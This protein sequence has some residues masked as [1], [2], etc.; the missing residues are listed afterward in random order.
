MSLPA[1]GKICVVIRE[2]NADDFQKAILHNR[3]N[4]DLME[5]R[6]DYLNSSQL[7]IKQLRYWV[8]IS[9]VPVIATL[10]RKPFGGLFS[11]SPNEQM[12]IVNKIQGAGFDFVDIELETLEVIDSEQLEK[13][14]AGSMKLIASYHNFKE[15]PS[16]LKSVFDRIVVFRPEVVK[17]AT[18]ALSFS[19]NF[20]LI[21]LISQAT[22]RGLMIIPV[23]MGELGVYSRVIAPSRGA[24]L[25]YASSQAGQETAP[26]Q[27]TALGLKDVYQLNLIDQSTLIYGVI[28]CPIKHSMSPYIH[29]YAFQKVGLK[30]C[31]LPLYIPSLKEFGPYLGSFSGLSVT[32]PHKVSIL[33]YVGFKD[34]SVEESGAANT[35]VKKIDGFGAYNT[36]PEGVRFALRDVLGH[37][38]S[39]RTVLL[40]A[41]GAA[42]SAAVVLKEK[43]CDVTVLARNQRKAE[44]FAK[45]FDFS[46]G[47]LD[48][49]EGYRGDLL[50]NATPI[51]MSPANHETPV[52]EEALNYDVVFDMIYNPL[53]T[54]L[55]REAQRKA[56]IVSG[57]EMFVGQAAYQF[58]LWT[59]KNISKGTL[60]EVVFGQLQNR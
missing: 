24:L 44:V 5:F 54:R 30:S 7:N 43:G 17:I 15:T 25:T 35:L 18:M 57:L 28:G 38:S 46:S 34:Q 21:E 27:F 29:N 37:V 12:D 2:H 52:P 48:D 47:S 50:I 45:D 26:G 49:V 1:K 4:S 3:D 23:A 60:R 41:G 10:R 11:G 59:G 40:G 36:D 19:D 32:L 13:V 39:C 9:G 42:R 55:L 8:A 51:G 33:D 22:E 53:E 56:K 20:R 6:L 31:Y 58:Q 14:R 16:N